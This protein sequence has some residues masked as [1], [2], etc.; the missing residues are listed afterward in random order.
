[1]IKKVVIFLLGG[2]IIGVGFGATLFVP[3]SAAHSS[4]DIGSPVPDFVLSGVQSQ[5]IRLEDFRGKAV[6]LNFWATWCAPCKQEMPLL[7]KF[8][9]TFGTSVVVIGIDSQEQATDV[10]T[11]LQENQIQFPV[12]LDLDGEITRKYQV[13]GFPT[14]FFL[15]QNGIL[16]SEQIGALR[17]DLLQDHLQAVGVKP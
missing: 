11:Y 4:I 16:R 12:A 14:T 13:N 8:A 7:Q 1:L 2:L 15:D 9:D 17:E 3:G 10:A 5:K 6:I